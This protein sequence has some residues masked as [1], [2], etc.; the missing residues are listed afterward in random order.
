MKISVVVTVVNEAA[1]IAKLICSLEKQSQKADEIIIVDGGSSDS[2]T[3]I[4]R[5]YQKKNSSIKL[6]T[7]I[8]SRSRGRNLGI[9]ISRNKII[10][11]TDAGCIANP[12][13]IKRITQPLKNLNIKLVAGFYKMITKNNFQKAESIFLGVLPSKINKNYLPST[14]SMAFTKDLWEHVGGF[15]ENM[16]DTAEDTMFDYQLLK[17]NIRIEVVENAIVEWELPYNLKMFYK[18]IFL[19]AKGDCKSKIWFFPK[20][21]TVS[22]NIKALSIFLRY[23][24]GL[25]LTIW[26]IDLKIF[27]ELP[28]ILLG[29]YFYWSFSKIFREYKNVG[30]SIWG[31]LLQFTA[32]IAVMGGFIN[33]IF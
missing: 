12:E 1:T 33:G 23:L 8:C 16:K 15:K 29:L 17:N 18:K 9:E 14:R 26:S 31:I 6:L 24:F 11:L 3:E 4:I 21:K 20:T 32:D 25:I 28:L 13:W 19:Y 5:H 30:A 10:V 7:E 22:H 27:P 2:T